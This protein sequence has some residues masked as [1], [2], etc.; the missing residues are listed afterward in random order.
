MQ[1]REFLQTLPAAA[2]G[3]APAARHNVLLLLSDEH[4]P[5]YSEPYGH[6]FVATPNMA[7]L[8]RRGTVFQN[9]YCPSPLCL[10]SR[11]SFLSGRRVFDLQTYGNC[12]V[13]PVDTPSYG[14]VLDEQGVHSVHIGKTDVYNQ[15]ST[16]G[17]S[18]MI[19]P[20]D[21]ARPGDTLVSRIPLDVQ[22]DGAHRG[23][24]YGVTA[25]PFGGD[26]KKVDL[27]LEWLARKAPSMTKPWT[28]AVNLLKPHFPHNVTP[29]LWAQ[30]A[31]HADLPKYGVNSVGAKHPYT[32][33]LRKFFA[34]DNYDAETIRC[35][36]RG[37]YGC[38]TFVDQQLGRLVEALEKSGQAEN[39]VVI[40]TSDH[41][42]MLG[43]FGL[44]WKRSLYED[45]AR[46]P[47][48]AAG[49]GFRAGARVQTPVDLH[50]L[51]AS[52]FQAT[53]A[54]QPAAWCGQPLQSMPAGDDG[55]VV[56]SEFQG[57][58]TRASAF[59]VR[60]G[61]WKLI[62]NCAAPHQLFDLEKDP[63]EL[64]NLAMS[65]PKIVRRLEQELR[66]ICDPQQEN[67][68]A[69]DYTQRQLRALGR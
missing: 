58:G 46:I 36:R 16:L 55:R 65:Q 30:Y 38:V 3:A 22:K 9:A 20:G 1:R 41:G 44:W 31:Q 14:H 17:F 68:R 34:T 51:R 24:G 25:N 33:D 64:S 32:E 52:M 47:M 63:D 5:L 56:F 12:N 69:E 26:L 27:A 29:E 23:A 60:Q 66:R 13:F 54:K 40:Y 6:P 15:A 67:R 2:L 49:P 59:L 35:L 48:I 50:D 43:K 10:P 21:R 39:T 4:N 28:L 62:Y 45:S 57:G 8:A 19:A 53:G 37:Y 7:K 11:S 42:E 18:E 61:R